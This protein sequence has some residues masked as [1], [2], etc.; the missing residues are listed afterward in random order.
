MGLW[1]RR[2]VALIV[3]TDGWN[4]A[5]EAELAG[6][7]V[8]GTKQATPTSHSCGTCPPTHPV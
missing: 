6:P 3:E 4:E 2:R 5:S 7:P 1:L 8:L